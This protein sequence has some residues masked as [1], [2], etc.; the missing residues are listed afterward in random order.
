MTKAE[1]LKKLKALQKTSQKD[2]EIAHIE[3]DDLL[4]AYIKDPKISKAFK[5]ILR[6]YS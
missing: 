6:W 1:L 4:L 5:A 2:A 3:A